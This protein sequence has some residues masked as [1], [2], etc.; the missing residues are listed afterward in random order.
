MKA[1]YHHLPYRITIQ[2]DLFIQE[3]ASL[4]HPH[5]LNC[6]P[7]PIRAVV[8]VLHESFVMLPH[9]LSAF[10]VKTLL[11]WHFKFFYAED[12]P[13]MSINPQI[14]MDMAMDKSLTLVDIFKKR[15]LKQ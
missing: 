4:T 14:L 13:Q 10:S 12:L 9:V 8:S 2:K 11:L 15:Q 5:I 6:N 7:L 3:L 1:L